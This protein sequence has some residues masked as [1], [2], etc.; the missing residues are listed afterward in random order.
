MQ[1]NQDMFRGLSSSS[2]FISKFI[3]CYFL[4]VGHVCLSVCLYHGVGLFVPRHMCGGQRTA[5][6]SRFSPHFYIGSGN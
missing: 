4:Y 5:L 1:R 3:Y 2:V 6:W